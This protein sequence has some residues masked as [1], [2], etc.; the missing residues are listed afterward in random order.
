MV[1]VYVSM[2]IALLL[3]LILSVPYIDF[4]KKNLLGQYIYEDA[5]EQ[6]N[7][8]AGTPTMGGIII[9]ICVMLASVL[10]L[11]MFESFSSKV[12]IVLL[13]FILFAVAGFVDDYKK[14]VKKTNKGL[15]ALSKLIIQL[16]AALI[17]SLYMI[18]THQT[19]ISVFD[20]FHVNLGYF[21]LLFSLFVIIGTSN[22]V[23]LTDGL[24][25]LAAGLS[26]ISFLT[27][28]VMFCLSNDIELAIISAAVFAACLGFLFYNRYPAKIFMGDTGS[29]ALGGV[30]AVLAIVGKLELWLI[31]IGLVF[32]IETLSVIIQVISFKTTGKRVFKM[33]PIHH[34]FELLGW[35]EKKVVYVFYLVGLI[36]AI[37][38]LV[39]YIV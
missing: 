20:L 22:A 23:N 15:K 3:M 36:S 28:T 16:T 39:W 31:P 2:L 38:A 26:C 37:A 29:L 12:F 7:K 9:L 24:D 5:P 32:I 25:G 21:Y 13:S 11:V 18:F 35:S 1:L 33:S 4:L 14:L 17:P 30:L 6:H 19:D 27:L 8:K 34:H 10:S